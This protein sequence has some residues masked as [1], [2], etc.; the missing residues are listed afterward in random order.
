MRLSDW[1]TLSRF[2]AESP[3]VDDLFAAFVGWKP[4]GAE[5]QVSTEEQ[6]LAFAMFAGGL[7]LG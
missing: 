6:L 4:G 7:K 5:V 2:W 3:S 1:A